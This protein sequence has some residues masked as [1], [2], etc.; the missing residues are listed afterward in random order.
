MARLTCNLVILLL[1]ATV[2]SCSTQDD[3]VLKQLD[4]AI[5]NTSAHDASK[6]NAIAQLKAQRS[7]AESPRRI[8]ELNKHLFS[9]YESYVCDSALNYTRQN[10]ALARQMADSTL[11]I[12]TILDQS[13][14]L[15]KAGLFFEA[16]KLM[17]SINTDQVPQDL[18]GHY[19]HN[20]YE[21]YLYMSEYASG[22]EYIP[23]YQAL[24]NRYFDAT[25]QSADHNSFTYIS[26]YAQKLIKD[27]KI[28]QA[29]AY[30]DAEMKQYKSGMREYSILA[31]II[32]YYY[33]CK[34][35]EKNAA[36][37]L[38][39]SAISDIEGSIKENVSIRELAR[40]LYIM[41]D[42]ERS[43]TYLEKSLDDATF[44]SARLRNI[45][46]SSL[47]VNASE[48]YGKMQKDNERTLLSLT[49]A[50]LVLALALIVALGMIAR[51]MSRLRKS[52]D[53]LSQAKNELSTLNS[54]L[55]DINQRTESANQALKEAN[56]LR[57]MCI[58][59]FMVLCSSSIKTLDQYR[60]N[61]LKKLVARKIDELHNDLKSTR[62]VNDTLH[63]FYHSF[64]VVFMS[65]FPNFINDFNLLL[66]DGEKEVVKEKDVLNT[67]LRV[68]ALIRMGI[69]DPNQIAEFLRCSITTVYTYRSK[70]KA[71]AI[72]PEHFEENILKIKG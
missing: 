31:S 47:L 72:D 24:V 58:S 44:F 53:K 4:Q 30:V 42:Y 49:I 35:D 62:M 15:A 13:Y 64:D 27:G 1:A 39:I 2:C 56:Q 55:V 41:G 22:T 45:Q 9:L 28:D 34:H 37:W 14:V 71:R 60:M 25:L 16:E 17:G 43:V 65:I 8:Y 19:N 18:K 40:R 33:E 12:E 11:L 32:S 54:Q 57:E 21:I 36:K 68:Y 52:H 20:Y 67:E 50:A 48:T 70:C 66:K 46:T 61:L 10:I 63:E 59:Q 3:A 51:Q 5:A 7:Q 69:N 26:I 38:A 23:Q 29:K 6:E